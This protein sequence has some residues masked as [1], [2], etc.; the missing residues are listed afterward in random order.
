M[1]LLWSSQVSL[2]QWDDWHSVLLKDVNF[3]ILPLYRRR[4][5]DEQAITYAGF[6]PGEYRVTITWAQ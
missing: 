6:V 1:L 3:T 5:D 4:E 2:L